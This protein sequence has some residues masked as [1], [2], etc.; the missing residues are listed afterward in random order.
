MRPG[1]GWLTPTVQDLNLDVVRRALDHWTGVERLSPEEAD[2]LFAENYA[3][4]KVFGRVRNLQEACNRC[5]VP[6]PMKQLL[7]AANAKRKRSGPPPATT[8]PP[9]PLTTPS[10]R[11]S[12]LKAKADGTSPHKAPMLKQVSFDER[13]VEFAIKPDKGAH[14]STGR[15]LP[16]ILSLDLSNI[17]NWWLLQ[18]S[19]LSA[20][21]A[22]YR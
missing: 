18:A 2:R 10:P 19:I 5:G 13:P 3:V 16:W 9:P 14:G 12:A 4:G 7:D 15:S 8:P 11:T 6:I 22:V 17:V 20:L 1:T 21:L